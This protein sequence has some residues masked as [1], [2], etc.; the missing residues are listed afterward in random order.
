MNFC[1][2]YVAPSPLGGEGWGEGAVYKSL[3][4]ARINA[5]PPHPGLLPQGEK[6][7]TICI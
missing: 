5:R 1:S 7:K 6:E 3:F 2:S 4:F